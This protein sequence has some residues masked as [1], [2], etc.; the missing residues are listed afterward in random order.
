M[1]GDIRYW[2]SGLNFPYHFLQSCI[3]CL[4]ELCWQV[5]EDEVLG[6]HLVAS[7]DIKAGEVVLREDPLLQGPC[8]VTGP[9]CLECL[10]GIS[11][12]NSEPCQHCGWPLCRKP[13]CRQPKRHLPECRWTAEKRKTPVSKCMDNYKTLMSPFILEAT[14]RDTTHC[15][16]V[17]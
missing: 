9:V 7:R 14:K 17:V 15:G 16:V 2:S 12:H 13:A 3:H 4:H 6:R 11:Q 1:F 8:Q 10:Q 5:H